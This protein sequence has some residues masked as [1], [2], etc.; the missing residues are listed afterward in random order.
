MYY[1]ENKMVIALT[2]YFI[3]L[4][5]E[6]PIVKVFGIYFMKKLFYQY[7]DTLFFG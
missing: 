3:Y 2:I 6:N 4:F 7:Y 5:S 1:Y